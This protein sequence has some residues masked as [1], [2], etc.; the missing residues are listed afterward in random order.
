MRA[1]ERQLSLQ[2][3][4]EEMMLQQPGSPWLP[5]TDTLISVP[6][7]EKELMT[8]ITAIVRMRSKRPDVLN[9]FDLVVRQTEISVSR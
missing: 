9:L 2:G 5:K 3:L 4:F 7:E 6:I 1:A 8:R